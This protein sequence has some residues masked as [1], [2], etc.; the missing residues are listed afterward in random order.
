MKP[1]KLGQGV[2]QLVCF[3]WIFFQI[4]DWF[5]VFFFFSRMQ[6]GSNCSL[7]CSSYCEE[8][9]CDR[10]SGECLYDC[11]P[12]YQMPNC[13]MSKIYLK[14]SLYLSV[15]HYA[16]T[17]KITKDL[18]LKQHYMYMHHNCL[19]KKRVVLTNYNNGYYGVNRRCYQTLDMYLVSKHKN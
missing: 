12:G 19:L 16:I 1:R 14:F 4:K 3:Q 15:Q 2:S 10:Y 7:N 9:A 8:K 11:T 6:T 17:I 5:I 18:Q 13:I